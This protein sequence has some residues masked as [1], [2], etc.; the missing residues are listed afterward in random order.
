MHIYGLGGGEKWVITCGWSHVTTATPPR[1]RG[2]G[3]G[4]GETPHHITN[5]SRA[6]SYHPIT[7]GLRKGRAPIEVFF[8]GSSPDGTWMHKGGRYLQ[9]GCVKNPLFST[10]F[11]RR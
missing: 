7:H 4:G 2:G 8:T 1:V 5:T 9:Y 3:G 10:V 6:F 11:R